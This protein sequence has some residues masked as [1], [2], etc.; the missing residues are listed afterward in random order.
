[1]ELEEAV[2][3]HRARSKERLMRSQPGSPSDYELLEIALFYSIP[4]K[5]VKLIAKT[6]LKKF[7]NLGN[8]VNA[9][10]ESLERI[11]GISNSSVILFRFLQEI[12]IRLAKEEFA[13]KPII[14]SWDNLIKYIR[15]NIGYRTTE[16]LHI[17][18]LN[19]KNMLIADE[20]QGY[21]TVNMVSVYPRE[22]VKAALYHDASSII[23]A[24]NH[25]SGVTKPSEAD[26]AITD[27]L[28]EALNS[29][30]ITLIDHVIISSNSYFSFKAHK[31]L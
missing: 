29:V 28:I 7:G 11:K 3:G 6:L 5:D 13:D 2:L 25:P 4:R 16:S 14:G 8:V 18:F 9:T 30:S 1:M 31:L 27:N 24:H 15:S 12:T 26:I 17:L 20:V 19:S 23:L 21:G 22:I 10:R